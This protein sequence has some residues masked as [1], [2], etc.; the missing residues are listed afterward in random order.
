M[1][2]KEEISIEQISHPHDMVRYTLRNGVY[3]T[4]VMNAQHR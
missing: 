4:R 1:S 2:I 3:G